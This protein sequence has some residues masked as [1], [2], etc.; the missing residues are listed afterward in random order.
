MAGSTQYSSAN[1]SCEARIPLFPL[2]Y[3]AHPRPKGGAAY[4]YD[5]PTLAKGFE[6]LDHAQYGLRCVGAGFVYLFDETEGKVFVWRVNEE[7]G[8]FIELQSRHRSLEAAIGGYKPGRSLPHIWAKECSVVHVL[9]TDTLLTERKIREI[10]SDQNGI[11]GKLATTIDMN[12][13]TDSAPARNTFSA[14]RMGEL[15][16]EFKGT[17]LSFSPWKIKH[18]TPSAQAL[19]TGMKAVAPAKQI[20]VV[21]HDNIALVQDL[22][23]MFHESRS[24]MESFT[25]APDAASNNNDIQRYR[26]TIIA[27]L[28]GR[29]YDSSY[30]N[31]K[32]I[33]PQ[34]K[35]GQQKLDKS[36]DREV[37][38]YEYKRKW[39]EDNLA[40]QER[41]LP[42]HH[43]SS[44]QRARRQL[45]AMP[46]NSADQRAEILALNAE[47]YSRHVKEK[48]RVAYLKNFELELEK[49][50]I[51]VL[52]NKNDRCLWLKAYPRSAAQADF[53]ATFLRYD[54]THPVASTSHAVAFAHCIEGMIW[55][56][57]TTPA[58]KK[59]HERELFSKWWALP[60]QENPIL[61]NLGHDKG[62]GD[63]I[64]ENKA[65][66]V[67]DTA[68]GKVVAGLLRFVAV[69]HL[70]HQVGVF[71]LTRP[72][73]W[74]GVVR[75]NVDALIHRLA[76]T[77]SEADAVH[78]RGL[79]EERYRDRI[80]PRRLSRAE[81]YV[82][83]EQASGIRGLT[84]EG[85]IAQRN[86]NAIVVLEWESLT[87]LTRN[88]NPFLQ[89]FE[90]GAASGVA[91]L[92]MWNLLNAVEQLE[93][94]ED[95]ANRA[96]QSNLVAAVLGTGSAVNGALIAT[97]TLAP[98]MF[99]NA[100]ILSSALRVMASTGVLRLFGYVGALVDAV[101]NW[102]KA[103]KQYQ[104]GN[105]TAGTYYA[106][107]G[108]GMFLGGIAL[109]NAGA[110]AITS[111]LGLAGMALGV[112]V[113]GWIV[114]GAILLGLGM[115]WL[116]NAEDAH[117]SEL[118]FWLNDG[119][120][121]KRALMGR[122]TAV[123]YSSLDSENKAY[124]EIN[125]SPKRI[126]SEWKIFGF[127][128][129]NV[130]Y[131]PGVATTYSPRL[132]VEVAYPLEGDIQH[133]QA[134]ITTGPSLANSSGSP[135]LDISIKEDTPKKLASGG[136]IRTYV[137]TGLRSNVEF[138]LSLTATYIPKLLSEPLTSTFSFTDEDTPWYY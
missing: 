68:V 72:A 93:I 110:G 35:G 63:T 56:T 58:G 39:M 10:E 3:S 43:P 129:P 118:E 52:D 105:T 12:A 119:T 74:R 135:R 117:Y 20:A 92:S 65:D 73:N 106:L 53:G 128:T 131:G 37:Y 130:P 95:L 6:T 44:Y 26:K 97:R 18:S 121:G 67:V 4:A 104:I 136:S 32:G 66:V 111:G 91:V 88:A 76:G 81:A 57:A 46:K 107:A 17:D 41:E 64:V 30:A 79:L 99:G 70:M 14:A 2:R 98:A 59:D 116:F 126:D 90:G 27:Q 50:H 5:E 40:V 31:S 101:T 1:E 29:I 22:G 100:S 24:N 71:T 102:F 86:G 60:W 51:A 87:P 54:L 124:V 7:N 16:E 36:L 47:R 132:V 33:N 77:G 69:Q 38:E 21:M 15:V 8:Q 96:T 62:F 127:D 115:W 11:R 13:W 55:G 34:D 94:G 45:N 83:I 49:R 112:P 109:T 114:A 61:E 125:Y 28:I 85:S 123:V 42:R 138:G 108:A 9:L 75:N 48:E 78:L 122:D 89:V 103:Q 134:V 19:V 133:I 80:V 82:R 120:F 113:W 84:V 23:G 137:I 25:S